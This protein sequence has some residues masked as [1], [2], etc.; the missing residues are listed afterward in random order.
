MRA[1]RRPT[2]A[3]SALP[4]EA[5]DAVAERF[6]LL[7]A[8]SRLRI[9]DALMGGALGMGALAEATGLEPS[10]LS[11]QVADL[12]R[13]GCVRRSRRGREVEVEIADPTLRP[14]CDLVCGA[15][16]QDARR[17]AAWLGAP[18]RRGGRA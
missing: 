18:A 16:R 10:N 12:E 17:R 8:P 9:L 5:L 3:R 7:G 2:P 15:L 1:P 4:P 13:G 11:R 6:R 14:L